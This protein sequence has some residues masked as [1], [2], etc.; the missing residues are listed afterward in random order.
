MSTPEENNYKNYLDRLEKFI[1]ENKNSLLIIG[2]SIVLLGALYFS[3]QQFYLAPRAIEAKNQMY[4][5]ER[6][7]EMDS[8]DKAINGDGNFEGFLAIADEYS[9]TKAANLANYYLGISYLKKGE[10]EKAIESLK[11]FKSSDIVISSMA[12]GAI[13]DAYT[14]LG[15]F[16]NAS[17]FYKKASGDKSNT[18]TA[19][20]YLLK[21][22]MSLEQQ[23]KSE[24]AFKVYKKIKEEYPESTQARDIDK[25]IGRTELN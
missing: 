23:K 16:D 10:F 11:N 5:A 8:L 18:Y 3:Y 17:S 4:Q 2:G 6:Y 7:F 9:G 20:I 22:G 24:D 21:L 12:K 14:E 25:Y 1:N 15:D 13:G 19:P